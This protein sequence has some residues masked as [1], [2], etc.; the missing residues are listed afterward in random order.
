VGQ[1]RADDRLKLADL[2]WSVGSAVLAVGMVS[3]L[4]TSNAFVLIGVALGTH[5]GVVELRQNLRGQAGL[6]VKIQAAVKRHRTALIR[7]R[8]MLV[9]TDAYGNE[10]L[11]NWNKEVARFV[12]T[13]IMPILTRTEFRVAQDATKL[14]ALLERHLFTPIMLDMKEAN[15]RLLAFDPAMPPLAFEAHCAMV[16]SVAGWQATTTQATGDQGADVVAEKNGYRV[17][18][19]AK[20]LTDPIGNKAVQEAYAAKSHYSATAAAVV[21]NSG[22]TASARQLAHSTGVLLLHHRD[23]PELEALITKT[24]YAS[25]EAA[26]RNFETSSRD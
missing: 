15:T 13:N 6:E 9:R 14:N 4:A 10:V 21:T 2:P 23:L 20:L 25:L 19:Q 16:L 8:Q 3:L 26:K 1:Q 11:E 22:F 5:G 7:Q 24:A 18:L 17:V 12:E